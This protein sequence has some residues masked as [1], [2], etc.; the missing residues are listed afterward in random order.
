MTY[1]TGG[2][3]ERWTL[4]CTDLFGEVRRAVIAPTRD[5]YGLLVAMPAD[6]IRMTARQAEEMARDLLDAASRRRAD[7]DE[8]ESS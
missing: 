4:L 1:D 7:G 8:K 2:Y 3:C 5:R 6:T